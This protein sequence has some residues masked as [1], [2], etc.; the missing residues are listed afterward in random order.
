MLTALA[1]WSVRLVEKKVGSGGSEKMIRFNF[2]VPV[3]IMFTTANIYLAYTKAMLGSALLMNIL[4]LT[5]IVSSFQDLKYENV[6]FI[7]LSQ[8]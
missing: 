6:N 7:S 1:F 5:A 2:A 8:N 4:L 3:F